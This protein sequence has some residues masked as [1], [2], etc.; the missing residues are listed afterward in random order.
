MHI[1]IAAIGKL[2]PSAPEHALMATFLKRLPWQVDMHELQ[3]KKKLPPAK[4]QAEEARLLL[5]V[6]P[7]DTQI[8]MLDERGKTPS[9]EAFA[10]LLCNWQESGIRRI[11]FLI[12]GAAG[13]H[14]SIR[15]RAGYVLSFG[16]M[17]WPHMLVRPML[18][19]QLY[20][21]YTIHTGHPYHR[22]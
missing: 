13:H 7:R 4:M 16:P 9:S 6:V 12:G 18:C 2:S 1:I 17:T 19:E 22:G 11:A 10:G 5:D 8:V 14:P 3:V 20:R 21:A 15:E